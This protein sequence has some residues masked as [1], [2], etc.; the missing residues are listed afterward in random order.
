MFF[1]RIQTPKRKL[2]QQKRIV[3]SSKNKI[4]ISNAIKMAKIEK[5]FKKYDKDTKKIN[6]KI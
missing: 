6:K 3:L 1:R 5:L 2:K 4:A